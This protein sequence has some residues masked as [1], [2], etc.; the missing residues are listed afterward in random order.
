MQ[1]I[2]LNWTY[3]KNLFLI[4]TYQFEQQNV[5]KKVVH[6]KLVH[7]AYSYYKLK[8]DELISLFNVMNNRKQPN[9]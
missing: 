9:R 4:V 8:K 6:V 3:W 2:D 1:E 5:Y 7:C